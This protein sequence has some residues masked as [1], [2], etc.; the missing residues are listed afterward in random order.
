MVTGGGVGSGSCFQVRMD[1]MEKINQLVKIEI[2]RA[3]A[4]IVKLE[5]G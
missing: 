2:A 1:I 5:R 4:N 3:E